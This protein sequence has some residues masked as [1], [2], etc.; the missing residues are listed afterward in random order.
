MNEDT[1]KTRRFKMNKNSETTERLLN[2]ARVIVLDSKVS[3]WLKDNDP[4]AYRQLVV[5]IS[6]SASH[7]P[8]EPD[9]MNIVELRKK[10]R[11]GCQDGSI[12]HYAPM[13]WNK[14]AAQWIA[15]ANKA[16]LSHAILT[17]GTKACSVTKAHV[18]SNGCP[19]CDK[20]AGLSM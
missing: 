9:A 7:S 12:F 16:Q 18:V 10:V 15:K 6:N 19:S 20:A 17:K 8:T 4:K 3:K 2:A 1:K 13:T 5:A 11:E 14:T